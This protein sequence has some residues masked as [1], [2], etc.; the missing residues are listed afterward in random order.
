M[1]NYLEYIRNSG[2]YKSKTIE[3]TLEFSKD[4]KD[5]IEVSVRIV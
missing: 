1:M 2:K 4:I 5:A 3:T